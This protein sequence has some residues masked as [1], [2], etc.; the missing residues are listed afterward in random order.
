M[1]LT[2]DPY[3][4]DNPYVDAMSNGLTYVVERFKDSPVAGHVTLRKGE[5]SCS[6]NSRRRC[7]DGSGTQRSTPGRGKRR[8]D[9]ARDP[10]SGRGSGRSRKGE[11]GREG[12]RRV[13]PIQIHGDQPRRPERG[14][15]SAEPR[16][17]GGPPGPP[18]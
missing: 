15:R 11:M 18:R 17:T 9:G 7:S 13:E 1:V 2:G 12:P 16:P 8:R 5:W 10:S 4:I 6:L 14:L 3:Q